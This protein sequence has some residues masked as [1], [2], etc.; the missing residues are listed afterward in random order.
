MQKSRNRSRCES[1][2]ESERGGK[3]FGPF[4]K[5]GGKRILKNGKRVSK[6]ARL[7]EEASGNF[8]RGKRGG[9]NK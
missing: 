3:G 8:R 5:K 4:F 9:V 7:G 2:K 6:Q 1:E